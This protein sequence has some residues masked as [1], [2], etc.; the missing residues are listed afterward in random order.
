MKP[1]LTIFT[2]LYNRKEYLPRLYASMKQQSVPDFEWLIVDDGSEDHPEELIKTWVQE[3]NP[4][5]IRYLKKENG[6]KHTA[7][8]L[9]LKEAVGEYFMSLDSDDYLT[10]DATSLIQSWI[11]DMPEDPDQMKLLGVAGQRIN[12][13]GEYLLWRNTE[14][15]ARVPYGGE[16]TF[17]DTLTCTMKDRI[18]RFG[19]PGDCSEVFRTK[20]L[21]RYPFPVFPGEKFLSEDAV[22]FPLSRDGWQLCFHREPLM[23]G[24][25][26]E[27][28]L[29]SDIDKF[30]LNPAG[31][32]YVIQMED[33]GSEEHEA[34]QYEYFHRLCEKLPFQ[35]ICAN[36]GVQEERTAQMLLKCCEKKL[37]QFPEIE[38]A[39][40]VYS[41]ILAQREQV[42]EGSERFLTISGIAQEVMKLLS[43][44]DPEVG[45]AAAQQGIPAAQALSEKKR[46]SIEAEMDM[47]R[48]KIN[49]RNF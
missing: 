45:I 44:L 4:F 42:P 28:G 14:Y 37:A 30:I 39:L 23:V 1:W 26:L 31:W 5:H 9:G 21:R 20:I 3:N 19:M 6:G 8:N 46:K 32:G 13:N 27:G 2:A 36:L 43:S 25:Y 10:K 12:S 29:S 11:H 35:T 18:D 15:G 33:C 48:H 16:P 34:H 40:L 24:N 49:D 47:L 7:M 38:E 22:F 17:S 41:N